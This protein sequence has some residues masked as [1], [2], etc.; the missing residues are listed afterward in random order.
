MASFNNLQV[1]SEYAKQAAIASTP[2][3]NRCE[4]SVNGVK[5]TA[6]T[7]GTITNPFQGA[8]YIYITR[9][10]LSANAAVVIAVGHSTSSSY[11]PI[12]DKSG[13]FVSDLFATD[14][15]KQYD[16]GAGVIVP[17]NE[18]IRLCASGAS[19]VFYTMTGYV[20]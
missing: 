5:E 16:F 1:V 8:K 17:A 6:A 12:A 19:T 14:I 9:L 11:D 20:I 7:A 2:P 15:T 10:T 18:Y 4:F 3:S 13:D